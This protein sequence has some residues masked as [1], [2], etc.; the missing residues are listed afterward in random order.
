MRINIRLTNIWRPIK[1]AIISRYQD[2][3]FQICMVLFF[4][5]LFLLYIFIGS[6]F[7]NSKPSINLVVIY[8]VSKFPVNINEKLLKTSAKMSPNSIFINK[9]SYNW[10]TI[11]RK[12]DKND[13]K[14]VI[15]FKWILFLCVGRETMKKHKKDGTKA[16]E[17]LG[18][19]NK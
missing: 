1:H 3:F 15:K 18:T 7:E 12:Q 9:H 6:S 13:N 14:I 16:N 17:T 5:T 11:S 19:L 4:F 8:W 2:F 10:M